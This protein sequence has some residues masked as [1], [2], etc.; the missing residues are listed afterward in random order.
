MKGLV[1][2]MGTI[3]RLRS[4]NKE[5]FVHLHLHIWYC[6]EQYEPI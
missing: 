3:P 4:V 6:I 1:D 5:N 2:V